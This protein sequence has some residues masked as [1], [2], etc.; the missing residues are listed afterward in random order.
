MDCIFVC[1]VGGRGII[2]VWGRR[3]REEVPLTG[4]MSVHSFPVFTTPVLIKG[5]EVATLSGKPQQPVAAC[6]MESAVQESS[7]SPGQHLLCFSLPPHQR[8]LQL[9]VMHGYEEI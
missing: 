3:L 6:T 1:V 4:F 2:H 5:R 9:I 8:N 7:R